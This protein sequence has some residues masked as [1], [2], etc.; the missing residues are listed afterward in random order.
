MRSSLVWLLLLLGCP[1]SRSRYEAILELPW[2]ARVAAVAA[3]AP[4]AQV[5]LYLYAVEM[6]HPPDLEAAQLLDA[7]DSLV[8]G[9]LAVRLDAERDSERRTALLYLATSVLCG[10]GWPERS[11]GAP[12]AASMRR[13]VQYRPGD[14][15]SRGATAALR[16]DC[17]GPN[18]VYR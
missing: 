12:L 5:D 9:H 6:V 1:D 16:G 7:T 3:L 15:R 8:L 17:T 11:A 2:R 14:E 4:A 10:S 13:A 18:A